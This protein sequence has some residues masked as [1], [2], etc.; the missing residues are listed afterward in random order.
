[1]GSGPFDSKL[2]TGAFTTSLFAVGW[3]CDGA[4]CPL[5]LRA[6]GIQFERALV[7]FLRRACSGAS[8]A[9]GSVNAERLLGCVVAMPVLSLH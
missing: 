7:D 4:C 5:C 6:L 8:E 3:F 9:A 2:T 1:M